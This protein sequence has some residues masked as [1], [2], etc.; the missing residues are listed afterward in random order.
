[1]F[2]WQHLHDDAYFYGAFYGGFYVQQY[3]SLQG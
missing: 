3:C 2:E 1:V